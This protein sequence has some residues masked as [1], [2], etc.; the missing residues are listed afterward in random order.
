MALT[1]EEGREIV[2]LAR[3]TLDAHVSGSS[4]KIR[5][6]DTGCL[7]Q[8]RGVFVTLNI[9][10]EG[11]QILRGCIGFPY[12]VKKLGEAVQE[13]T[14]AAASEDPRFEPVAPSEL[15][16]MVVEVSVLTVPEVLQAERRQDLP[17][18]IRIGKD[19][20]IVSGYGTSGLLLP[21]VATEFG[22]AQ[23]D[24]LTQTCLKAGLPPDAWLD[25]RTQVQSFQAEIFAERSPGGEVVQVAAEGAERET[26]RQF[27]RP[28]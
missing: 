28:G 7:S 13:A 3:S 2:Q 24:F 18:R 11:S 25:S 20:L 19:G 26:A 9:S 15:D 22:L 5:S 8:T 27:Q 14:I 16:S 17:S 21:Q 6:W 12:P 1:L 23:D 10:R 4:L